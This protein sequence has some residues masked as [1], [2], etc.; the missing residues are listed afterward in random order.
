MKLVRSASA[1]SWTD[2]VKIGPASAVVAM[3]TRRSGIT[4]DVL[5]GVADRT[6]CAAEIPSKEAKVLR[7]IGSSNSASRTVPLNVTAG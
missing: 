6:T 4:C 7:S 3:V 1:A 5:D 2:D